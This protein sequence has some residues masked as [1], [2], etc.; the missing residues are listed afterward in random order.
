VPEW[1]TRS[2]YHYE[3]EVRN[4]MKASLTIS[5]ALKR[6]LDDDVVDIA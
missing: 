4:T 2:N 5:G 1:I 3:L 6:D